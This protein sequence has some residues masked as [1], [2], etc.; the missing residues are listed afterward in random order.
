[1]VIFAALGFPDALP[2]PDI[3]KEADRRLCA[4]EARDLMPRHEWRTERLPEPLPKK[5][6]PHSQPVVKEMFLDRHLELR[7]KLAEARLLLPTQQGLSLDP[8]F[9]LP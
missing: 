4:T 7:T 5:I 2:F 3:V 6:Y 1:M 8:V 9:L